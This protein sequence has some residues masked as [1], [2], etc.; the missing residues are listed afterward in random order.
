MIQKF[1]DTVTFS[2]DRHSYSRSSVEYIQLLH[3]KSL[4]SGYMLNDIALPTHALSCLASSEIVIF[5]AP[6]E[7]RTE[8]EDIDRMILHC[9]FPCFHP[10]VKT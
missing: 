10:Q 4:D 6:Q 3:Y 5:Y 7:P 2:T 1:V 8:D 9:D